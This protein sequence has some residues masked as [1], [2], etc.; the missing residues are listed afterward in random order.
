M[1]PTSPIT[2]QA[3]ARLFLPLSITV[4]LQHPTRTRLPQPSHPLLLA[5]Y[6]GLE[7]RGHT[8][9]QLVNERRFILTVDLHFDACFEGRLIYRKG[10]GRA[11]EALISLQAGHILL[12]LGMSTSLLGR[13]SLKS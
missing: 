6:E 9:S 8:K 13:L 12:L 1:M 4:T 10:V 7:A 5:G 11:S 2:T 3:L